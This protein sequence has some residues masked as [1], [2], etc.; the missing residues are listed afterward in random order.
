MAGSRLVHFGK[1]AAIL[2]CVFR[3]DRARFVLNTSERLPGTVKSGCSFSIAAPR[4]LLFRSRPN[5]PFDPP[6]RARYGPRSPSARRP[7]ERA[8]A[9]FAHGFTGIVV[10][11]ARKF[12]KF[13]T[14]SDSLMPPISCRHVRACR[15]AGAR[16]VPGRSTPPSAAVLIFTHIFSAGHRGYQSRHRCGPTARQNPA[17]G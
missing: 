17:K 15:R 10:R 13:F 9:P 1:M 5:P 16:P 4:Q 12:V 6:S 14:N 7:W 8:A 11:L 3:R 2:V